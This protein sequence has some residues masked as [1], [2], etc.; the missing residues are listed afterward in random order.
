MCIETKV[1]SMTSHS[2][3]VYDLK[4]GQLEEI[5]ANATVIKAA[6]YQ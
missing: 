6:N 5:S 2:S 4:L 1:E 3:T